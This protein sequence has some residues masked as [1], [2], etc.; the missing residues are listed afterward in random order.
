MPRPFCYS[1]DYARLRWIST[2]ATPTS[3]RPATGGS[4]L[5]TAATGRG[6]SILVVAETR[7]A[8]GA[9][10]GRCDC[11]TSRWPFIGST[12]TLAPTDTRLNRSMT[13]SLVRRMQP[14]DTRW[15]MV[16]GALV[17]WMRY[18]GVAEIHG[19]RAE[20][21]AR[22]AGHEAR[23]IRLARDHLRRRMPVRPFLLAGDGLR[24]GPGEAFAADA[25]AVAD[26]AAVAEHVIE[27]GVGR[28]DHDRARR[29]A[30]VVGH[31]LAAEALAA[32]TPAARSV[33]LSSRHGLRRG[34]AAPP[35]GRSSR[36]RKARVVHG[37]RLGGA[38]AL[39]R[40]VAANA[41]TARRQ[42]L[43]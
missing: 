11:A 7:C 34:F 17:P 23:Q 29:L 28:I 16:D 5:G 26:R 40:R 9:G 18:I 20:R 39:D 43:G 3:R 2:A 25:D 32:T 31:H 30:G 10:A 19:A 36:E 15:P 21:I 6:A 37:E 22:A 41:E 14:D 42:W 13:S 8:H 24:A 38:G 12:T 1:I 27:I 33:T 35:A 4:A